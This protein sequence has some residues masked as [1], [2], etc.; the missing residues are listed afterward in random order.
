MA[1]EPR[2]KSS[3]T[4]TKKNDARGWTNQDEVIFSYDGCRVSL[5]WDPTSATIEVEGADAETRR[6]I[7]LSLWEMC[8]LYDGYFYTPKS[9][10]DGETAIS[11]KSL[12]PL[13]LYESSQDVVRSARPLC[14]SDRDITAATL[15]EYR[16]LRNYGIE[17]RA[18]WR[19]LINAFYY[20]CS[21]SYSRVLIDHRFSLLLNICDGLRYNSQQEPASIEEGVKYVLGKM[22]VGL[23]KEGAGCVG[24]SRSNM[25]KTLA[26][27]RNEIDHYIP[28]KR[29]IGKHFAEG[30]SNTQYQYFVYVFHVAIRAALLDQIGAAVNTEACR[31]AL[32]DIVHWAASVTGDGLKSA[33]VAS[34][35]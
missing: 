2:M 15:S 1:G 32:E 7:I 17:Q 29:S 30:T 6:A 26:D 33:G 28:Q 18:M 23:V 14:Q 13:N 24:I 9:Y 10:L 22:D 11:L 3:V 31:K 25:Y 27:A 4:F 19:E 34:R 5:I 35:M 8:F 21:D 12:F 20:L 16:S